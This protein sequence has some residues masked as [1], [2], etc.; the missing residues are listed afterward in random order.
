MILHSRKLALIG[1]VFFLFIMVSGV[2]GCKSVQDKKSE[3]I[4][5]TVTSLTHTWGNISDQQTQIKSRAMVKNPYPFAIVLKTIDYDVMLGD[6][7]VVHGVITKNQELPSPSE[8]EVTFEAVLDN[9]MLSQL[10]V[11]H[12]RNK[13]QTT[14]TYKGNMVF[15]LRGVDWKYSFKQPYEIKTNLL[16]QRSR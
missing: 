7:V 11:T 12:L 16:G 8:T 4:T 15:D 10:W 3:A 9:A 6:T 2:V 13:E 5:P 1:I 14:F